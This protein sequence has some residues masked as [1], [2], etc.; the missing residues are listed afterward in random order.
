MESFLKAMLVSVLLI[1]S[2]NVF[3]QQFGKLPNIQSKKKKPIT[4]LAEKLDPSLQADEDVMPFIKGKGGAPKNNMS[5]FVKDVKIK[6]PKLGGTGCPEGTIGASITPDGKTISL[7]FDNYIAQAG[8]SAGV[9]RD[10]KTCSVELPIE[11]PAGYQ[12]TIVK[13]DYRGFN[14]IP[15]GG[16]ARYVT[17]YS[18]LDGD[19][20]KQVGRRIRRNF[21]FNGPLSEDYTISSDVSSKPIWSTCGKSMVFRLDTRAVAVTNEDRE[22]VV[23]TID[24]ID[25]AAGSSVD[26]YLTWQECKNPEPVKPP[27]KQPGGG[28]NPFPIPNPGGGKGPFGGFIGGKK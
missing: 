27:G 5:A 8:Q 13:L 7:L 4:D 12:F 28:K 10:I 22:D 19:T 21:V 17:I 14:S 1:M 9:N 23:A 16:V 24:S 3:G 6:Q 18:F 15:D 20:K 25:A 26:Y 11:V 2:P